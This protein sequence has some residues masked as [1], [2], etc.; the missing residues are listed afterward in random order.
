V[1]LTGSLLISSL[2]SLNVIL[3]FLFI[4]VPHWY[5]KHMKPTYLLWTPTKG[6]L[7][8]KLSREIKSLP[9]RKD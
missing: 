6:S 7:Q 2:F 8:S 3:K 4:K 9:S 1:A 5:E